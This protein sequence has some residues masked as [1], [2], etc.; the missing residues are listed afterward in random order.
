MREPNFGEGQLQQSVNSTIQFEIFN[1][2][3]IRVSVKVPT[4][5]REFHLGWDSGFYFSWVPFPR[6]LQHDGCNFF[7]QYKLSKELTTP[8][9]AQYRCWNCS[10]M[11]FRIPYKNR[12][13]EDYSQWDR[14]KEIADIGYPSFYCTNSI[15][16]LTELEQFEEA[17]TLLD[18][19]PFLD[20]REINSRHIYATFTRNSSHFLL[21]S[22]QE[23]VHGIR[24]QAL[25][26]KLMQEEKSSLLDGN[27]KLYKTLVVLGEKFHSRLLSGILAEYPE[28][29]EQVSDEQMEVIGTLQFLHLQAAFRKLFGLSLHRF[30]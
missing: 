16:E 4:L 22:E 2:L 23:E 3:G 7:I 21:H 10:Y 1:H 29:P 18:E 15:L 24:W 5:P 17:G 13:T 27:R 26:E 11:R 14:M 30:Y 20:I 28:I 19:T 8:G 6:L 9:A 12:G 25:Q